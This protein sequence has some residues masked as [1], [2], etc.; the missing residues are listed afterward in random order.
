MREAEREMESMK[1]RS[2]RT[3]DLQF[4]QQG[5]QKTAARAKGKREKQGEKVDLT[6][7]VS[8]F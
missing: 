8:R 2:L 5:T 4:P 7:G 6:V 1:Q 3:D